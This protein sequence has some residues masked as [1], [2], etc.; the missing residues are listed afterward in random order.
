L[1]HN[2]DTDDPQTGPQAIVG[3]RS[4]RAG[5]VSQDDALVLFRPFKDDRIGFFVK[6]DVLNP[7][8]FQ[9]R[10][11]PEQTAQDTPVEVLVGQKLQWHA[12]VC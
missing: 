10:V 12:Y 4:H 7:N 1:R 11:P 8:D 2:A 5:I 6:T 9:V 3:R